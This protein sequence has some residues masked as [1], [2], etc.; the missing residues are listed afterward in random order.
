[1][2]EIISISGSHRTNHVLTQ[3]YNCQEE[4]LHDVNGQ[5]EPEVFLSPV[6]DK[7][8]NTVSYSPR[9]LLWDAKGGAGSLGSHE[10]ESS[11]DYYFDPAR[12]PDEA[13][14][15]GVQVIQTHGRVP[16]SDYQKAIDSNGTLP[17]LDDTNTRYWSDY[18]KLV[19]ES[20]NLN[21]LRD[22]Y[23]NVEDP[24]LP[25]FQN[26]HQTYFSSYEVGYHVFKNDYSTD[27]FDEKLHPQL[28]SCDGLQGINLLSEIDKGWGGFTSS[29]LL[30]MRDE[31]PKTDIL[32]WG[33]SE[34]DA[35]SLGQPIRS[36]KTK[37]E[38]ICNK[39]RSTLSLVRDSN[40]FFPLYSDPQQS[41]WRSAGASNLL[42]DAVISTASNRLAENRSLFRQTVG[43]LTQGESRRNI[44]SEL[45]VDSLD[46]SFYSRIPR[47]KTTGTKTYTRVA[48]T[49]D[50]E[51]IVDEPWMLKT[52]KWQPSDTIPSDYKQN[53]TYTASL[54]VTE[55]PRDVFKNWFGLVSRYFRYDSDREE[56]KEELGTLASEYEEGWYDDDESGD[57]F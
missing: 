12:K 26:L 6:V 53:T 4:L 35:L 2:R 55:K 54:A 32:T 57:D 44:V 27:F 42:F 28:E 18:S 31:L 50:P 46:F 36:T 38:L 11:H 56:L 43:M 29:L 21:S 40:L 7:I 3:F 34:D 22:W 25:D 19:F 9:A 17:K 52:Y 13:T 47:I 20:S 23:H 15:E 51:C 8:S 49:R 39:I 30:E 16:K 33:F 10:Y 48:I 41:L 37:F 45:N 1:M 24:S 14:Q 5:N